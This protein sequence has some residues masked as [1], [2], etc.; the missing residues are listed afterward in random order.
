MKKPDGELFLKPEILRTDMWMLPENK[1]GTPFLYVDNGGVFDVLCEDGN[2]IPYF[3]YE[4]ESF[5]NYKEENIK[6]FK[7]LL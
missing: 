2:N 7:L 1:I 4:V 6:L 3:K 5:I